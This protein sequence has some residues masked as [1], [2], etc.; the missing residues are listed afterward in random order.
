ATFP[1]A[2]SLATS[3]GWQQPLEVA[4]LI[5]GLEILASL[6]LEPW[7]YAAGTGISPLAVLLSALFWSWL[8]G[9]IG[10]ILATPLTVCLVVLGKYVPQLHFLYLMLSD[11]PA[12]P[13][14]ARLYQRLLTEEHDEA[15]S[16]L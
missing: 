9:P 6:V 3:S 4:G 12:L 16:I 10:L 11:A 13:P 5:V 2:L 7:F 1:L 8:W 14:A 15:W